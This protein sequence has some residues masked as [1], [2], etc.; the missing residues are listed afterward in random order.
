MIAT[1]LDI[2]CGINYR[3]FQHKVGA[4]NDLVNYVRRVANQYKGYSRWIDPTSDTREE[5][6]FN[7]VRY[8]YTRANHDSQR[9]AR[10]KYKK[11]IDESLN[12]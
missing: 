9:K 7:Y 12:E 2:I 4:V 11:K 1:I 8:V 6:I 10:T 3:P 5:K